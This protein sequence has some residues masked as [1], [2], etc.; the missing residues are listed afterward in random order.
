MVAGKDI[1]RISVP[2]AAG[3]CAAAILFSRMDNALG[4]RCII[5]GTIPSVIAAILLAVLRSVGS[6]ASRNP[7]LWSAVFFLTGCLCYA[8]SLTMIRPMEAGKYFPGA[9]EKIAF[10]IDSIPFRDREN[11][12]L[13]KALILGERSGLARETVSAFRTAG[14]AHLLALSGMH[15]GIIYLAINRIL[16]IFGNSI[17]VRKIRNIVTI[18]LCGLYTLLCGAG[19]S[20]VR[21]WLFIAL[22]ETAKFM[23]RPQPPQQIFCSALTLHLIFKPE[24]IGDIGFQLSYL[25]MVG[26]VFV[27]PWMREWYKAGGIGRKIWEGASLSL[28]CQL[29]TAPFTLI[30]FGTFPKYFLITNLVASPL[31]GI[32]MGCGVAAICFEAFGGDGACAWVFSACEAPFELLRTLLGLIAGMDSA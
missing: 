12:A 2:L 23:D 20:L 17:P 11:N 6:P 1:Y 13:A 9:S 15:L 27:W 26:I 18:C 32:V 8:T 30:Y 31:M 4:W 7:M 16:L 22:N 29:F 10:L 21:A 24:S 3:V 14:A 25:A 5:T 19:A 28:C